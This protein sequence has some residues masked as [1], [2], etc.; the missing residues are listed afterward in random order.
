LI[1]EG[2]RGALV[3]AQLGQLRKKEEVITET[4]ITTLPAKNVH[5]ALGG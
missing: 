5:S 2:R 3:F 1:A 4:A